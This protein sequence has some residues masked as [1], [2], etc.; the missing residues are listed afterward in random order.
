MGLSKEEQAFRRGYCHGFFNA[1]HPDNEKLTYKE[2][3]DWRDSE[4]ENNDKFPPGC[5]LNKFKKEKQNFGCTSFLVEEED[6]KYEKELQIKLK[7]MGISR[8]EYKKFIFWKH[9]ELTLNDE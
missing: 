6:A 5:F 7:K 2:I 1:R 8:E 9:C 3:R 4:E